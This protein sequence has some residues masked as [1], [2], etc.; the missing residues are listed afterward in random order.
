MSHTT[1]ENNK[2]IS[3]EVRNDLPSYIPT[4]LHVH[5]IHTL[6]ANTRKQTLKVCGPAGNDC[7]K[8]VIF[9]VSCL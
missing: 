4:D 7:K 2:I 8:T 3:E 1:R 9:D 6:H 5:E